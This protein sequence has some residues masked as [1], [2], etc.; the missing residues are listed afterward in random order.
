MCFTHTNSGYNK[1]KHFNMGEVTKEVFDSPAAKAK[2]VRREKK[3]KSRLHIYINDETI[4][5]IDQKANEMGI[6]RSNCLQVLINFG[7]EN[8]KMKHA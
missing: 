4:S 2:K 8:L 6:N 3:P 7:L 1:H 5:Q